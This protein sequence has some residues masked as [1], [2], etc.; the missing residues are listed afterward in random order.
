MDEVPWVDY[1]PGKTFPPYMQTFQGRIPNESRRDCKPSTEG[2]KK[3]SAIKRKGQ[4][5]D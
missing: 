1:K 2:F 5:N 3:T 4:Q